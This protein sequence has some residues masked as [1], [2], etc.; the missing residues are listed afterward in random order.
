[1]ATNTSNLARPLV[2]LVALVAAMAA[3]F[4]LAYDATSAKRPIPS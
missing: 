3:L 2:T 1:M 4:L